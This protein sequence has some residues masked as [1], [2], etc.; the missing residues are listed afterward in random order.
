MTSLFPL[1]M[2]LLNVNTVEIYWIAIMA[3]LYSADLCLQ[4]SI[5]MVGFLNAH[6]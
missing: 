3:Q 1:E 2:V 6:N 5:Q 4:K